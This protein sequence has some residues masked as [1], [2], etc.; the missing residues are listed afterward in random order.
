MCNVATLG[1]SKRTDRRKWA[2]E[3]SRHERT[4]LL[5]LLLVA[6]LVVVMALDVDADAL[7]E[8]TL[9][10]LDVVIVLDVEVRLVVAAAFRSDD[11]DATTAIIG[12]T[13]VEAVEFMVEVHGGDGA[14]RGKLV[15]PAV[16]RSTRSAGG[17][18]GHLGADATMGMGVTRLV[19]IGAGGLGL[20][21]FA[22]VED[23]A[24]SE[25]VGEHDGE[26]DV[27]ARHVGVGLVPWIQGQLKVRCN[28]C[29][30]QTCQ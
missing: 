15:D 27:Q 7:S 26:W 3:G 14:V 19:V 28:V 11:G 16:V 2:S 5:T 1:D 23:E 8:A 22:K 24:A 6:R 17:S 25:N 30:R 4:T 29:R 21:L 12:T 10:G 20:A 9:A 13:V 18:R